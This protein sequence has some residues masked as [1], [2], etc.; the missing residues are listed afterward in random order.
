MTVTVALTTFLSTSCGKRNRVAFFEDDEQ[1]GTQHFVAPLAFT[2]LAAIKKYR[3]RVR[4]YH[5]KTST[6]ANLFPL[7]TSTIEKV[8]KDSNSRWNSRAAKSDSHYTAT[9][10]T[11]E[12]IYLMKGFYIREHQKRFLSTFLLEKKCYI[13]L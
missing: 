12:S 6:S 1:P 13:F 9:N 5:S 10:C 2:R 11:L 8:N 4:V 7:S 3:L